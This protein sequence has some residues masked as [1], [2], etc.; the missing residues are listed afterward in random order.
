MTASMNADISVYR[1]PPTLWLAGLVLAAAIGAIFFD[2]LKYM[3]EQ[4][5]GMEEYSHGFLLPVIAIFLIWQKKDQ[6]EQIEFNGSWLGFA[7]AAFGFAVYLVGELSTLFIVIQYAFLTVLMGLAL[8][9]LGWRGFK[10]IF[11]P[12]ILLVLMIP[13]PNF[14]YQSLS[15]QLQLISSE[16]G[17]AVIRLFGV[18]VYLE[19]NVIDLGSFKM[20]VVEACSGLRYLFPLMTL[21]F[22]AAYF[23]KGVFWKRAVIFLSTIPITV[24][25]NSFRI[26][27]IGI[28]V[29]LWG[30]EMA[31]GFLHDFEGW[32]VFMASTAVLVS[33]M[34]LFAKLGKDPRP[35]REV[36]GLDF[37]APTP[38][39]VQRRVRPL[40]SPFIASAVMVLGVALMAGFLP[41]RVEVPPQRKEF[42]DF[43]LELGEW[44]GKGGQLESIYIDTLK[45]DDYVMADFTGPSAAPIN[46]YAA[47]YASQKKGESAHSPR[48]CIPG[49]G[50]EITSLEQRTIPNAS[51]AGNP[52]K[53]N[54]AVIQLGDTRQLVYYWFQ[55]RGRVI[56]NEYLV[57]WFLFWDALTRN[58]TDGAL[59]RL[60]T[61][62]LPGQDI[63]KADA[64]L[65]S[66]A[67]TA[68]KPL[69]AYIPD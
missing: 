66:F 36:F 41:E 20:Q 29:E 64:A 35:L 1:L 32:V 14:L 52:L 24:L 7:L 58:R 57:K 56:T 44:K 38:S 51:V 28:T 39:G 10:L 5:L 67:A 54:R 33:E 37:P 47:Y 26:G 45:F 9:L 40:P 69:G 62:V 61:L 60:T 12:L 21:G 23:F 6:L 30:P 4:W 43:P 48:T 17:V 22:V 50:W 27:M 8:S 53:V 34:W 15:S 11:V 63:V 13:L 19:G 42:S 18:S 49:G 25:M 46:F 16:I 31:E 59:V 2:S 65:S 68:T 3:V 55:Q